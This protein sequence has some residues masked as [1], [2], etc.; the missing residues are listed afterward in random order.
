M[1]F[2]RPTL[3]QLIERNRADLESR[4]AG[5]DAHLRRGIIPAL[6]TMHAGA[7]HGL[8]GYLDY[9]ARQANPATAEGEN[10]HAWA[11]I[12]LP[13]APKPA[14]P[15]KGNVT[16]TGTNT[17]VI[18][19]GT[20]V[21]RSDGAE[22]ETDE[23]AAIAAGT[24]TVAVTA[25]EAGASGNTGA[26]TVLSLSQAIAGVDGAVTVAAGGLSNGFE[27]ESDAD[28]LLRLK[29]R[30]QNP[31]AG[32]AAHDYVRWALEVPGVTRAWCL[33]GWL[34]GGTVGVTFV[35]DNQVG[36]ILPDGA[37]VAEVQAYIDA[38]AP[39]VANVTCFAPVAVE[40]DPTITL[41]PN[42]AAVQAAVEAELNDFLLRDTEP[43]K[44]VLWSKLHEAISL[45]E[46]EEDHVLTLPAGNVVLA[47]NEIAV[48]GTIT[49]A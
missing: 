13:N 5:T 38:L 45:A 17:T 40:L 46:G 39:V 23:V 16:F 11:R 26:G 4:L 49:W 34:G 30:V 6:A 21:V 8:Y 35:L 19:Q 7:L 44:T 48:L 14:T 22:F 18:P 33:P 41:T 24:A 37:K 10:L 32:G 9:K 36:G 42:T 3:A 20:A 28:L 1:P 27:I 29:Q 43:G 15:A 12:W 31:P 25:L 47:G 2:E